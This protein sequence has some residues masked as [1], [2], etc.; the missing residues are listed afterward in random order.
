MARDGQGG[1]QI[2]TVLFP[3][4]VG[5]CPVIIIIVSTSVT[6]LLVLFKLLNHV[7]VRM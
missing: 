2:T 1:H 6:L 4:D 7:A 3:V 5:L